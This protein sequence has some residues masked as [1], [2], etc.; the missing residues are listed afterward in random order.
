MPHAKVF[1][2]PKSSGRSERYSIRS[3]AIGTL[4][5]DVTGLIEEDQLGAVCY[6]GGGEFG[7]ACFSSPSRWRARLCGA[8]LSR[9]MHPLTIERTIVLERL[10]L[11]L[12]RHPDPESSSG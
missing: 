1:A 6:R 9:A 10:A 8:M 11:N 2:D 12:N 3:A 5:H 4:T 7:K